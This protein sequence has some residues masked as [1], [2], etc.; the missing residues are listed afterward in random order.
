MKTIIVEDEKF[1]R[2]NLV[3]LIHEIDPTIEVQAQLDTV[4][5]TVEYLKTTY[6]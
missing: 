5:E 6:S 2:E 3:Q 1:A 4:Q